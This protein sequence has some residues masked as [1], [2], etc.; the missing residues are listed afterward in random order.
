MLSLLLSCVG[1]KLYFLYSRV[2]SVLFSTF[3]YFFTNNIA[4]RTSRGQVTRL[5]QV[6]FLRG[7]PGQKSIQFV[8]AILWNTLPPLARSIHN[9]FPFLINLSQHLTWQLWKSYKTFRCLTC[10]NALLLAT[11]LLFL[12]HLSCRAMTIAFK[13]L[14]SNSYTVYDYL[15]FRHVK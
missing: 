2:L 13:F 5:L 12:P 4:H 6:P 14:I 15:Y 10:C 9:L 7:P 11:T 8:G 3:F 1:W